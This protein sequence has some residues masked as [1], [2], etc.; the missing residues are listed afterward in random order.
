MSNRIGNGVAQKFQSIKRHLREMN[1]KERKFENCLYAPRDMIRSL[2]PITNNDLQNLC[3]DLMNKTSSKIIIKGG[4][5]VHSV[6][7]VKAFMK[8]SFCF[9]ETLYKVLIPTNENMNTEIASKFSTY[10]NGWERIRNQTVKRL[11]EYDSTVKLWTATRKGHPMHQPLPHTIYYDDKPECY[12]RLRRLEIPFGHVAARKELRRVMH[13]LHGATYSDF[14]TKWEHSEDLRRRLLK[15]VRIASH[16]APKSSTS[17]KNLSNLVVHSLKTE[18]LKNIEVNAYNLG[19]VTEDEDYD[20]RRA[21]AAFQEPTERL[22]PLAFTTTYKTSLYAHCPEYLNPAAV[23]DVK[24]PDGYTKSNAAIE[25]NVVIQ[26]LLTPWPRK[27]DCVH[28]FTHHKAIKDVLPKNV[29]ISKIEVKRSSS[30]W[31]KI[32]RGEADN[33][34][35]LK[36]LEELDWKG[37]RGFTEQAIDIGGLKLR[38]NATNDILTEE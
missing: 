34:E 20:F 38:K 11:M 35:E 17:S 4:T 22:I 3:V 5:E 28:D 23:L 26:N 1:E 12:D 30:I 31:A 36:Q 2:K 16:V 32:L 33:I 10:G 9:T 18:L 21:V 8:E 25:I 24:T 6:E 37:K 29:D 27:Y 7:L 14:M 15:A 13:S 19:Y